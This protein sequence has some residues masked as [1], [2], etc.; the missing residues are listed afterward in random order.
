MNYRLKSIKSTCTW[1]EGPDVLLTIEYDNDKTQWLDLTSREARILSN[2]LI[3][4][5]QYAEDM[6]KSVREYFKNVDDIVDK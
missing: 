4:S 1:G 3:V 2:Q 5:A 6:D